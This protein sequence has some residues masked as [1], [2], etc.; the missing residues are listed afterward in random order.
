M[1]PNSTNTQHLSAL[2]D[3]KFQVLK[4]LVRLSRRQVELIEAGDMTMLIKLLAAKQTVMGQLQA[5][6]QQLTPFRSDDPEQRQWASP[7][8]R[9]A[10]QAQA[11][12]GNGLLAEAF[13][14]EQQ[15]ETA[16][17]RRRDA[18]AIALVSVQS[19][20]DARAAY[21]GAAPAS[22]VRAEG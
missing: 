13:A 17:K 10:C 11:E 1:T 21:V 7:G 16:M 20:A 2:V 22:S 14:L 9:A 12:A 15:A 6:E 3:A 18:A 5:I 19:A 4:V 8:Q